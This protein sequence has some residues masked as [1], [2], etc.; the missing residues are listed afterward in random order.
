[1]GLMQETTPQRNENTTR[2]LSAAVMAPIAMGL[3]LLGGIWVFALAIF[4]GA[5]A[6]FEWGRLVDARRHWLLTPL[7]LVT[8]V[9]VVMATW[10]HGF[11][12]GIVVAALGAAVAAVISNALR[13]TSKSLMSLGIFYCSLMT[14]AL[15]CLG[16]SYVPHGSLAWLFCVIWSADSAAYII[17]RTVGGP[18]LAPSISPGKTWSGLSAAILGGG[19]AGILASLLGIGVGSQL[20]CGIAGALLAAIGQGG[21]LFESWLKR[22]AG[23]KDSGG[24]IPGHGGVLDRVD[25]LMAASVILA[26]SLTL[27]GYHLP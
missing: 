26:G 27:C 18:K 10:E 21:D 3:S 14:S 1:M 17:G 11:Y 12:G 8:Q 24:C 16:D 9:I 6:S 23:V 19:V 7:A 25:A 15:C 2:L 5:S 13:L 20:I 4:I 22:R